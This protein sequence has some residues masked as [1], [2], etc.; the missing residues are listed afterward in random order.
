[1][2]FFKEIYF[3][4]DF[5]K[6]YK[7]SRSFRRFVNRSFR[8]FQQCDWG[9]I[10]YDDWMINEAAFRNSN[11]IISRYISKVYTLYITIEADRSYLSLLLPEEYL[12]EVM[13]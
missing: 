4:R 3:S 12:K 2:I 11:R 13:L 8:R 6:K 7:T 1:M 5:M 9:E 10:S